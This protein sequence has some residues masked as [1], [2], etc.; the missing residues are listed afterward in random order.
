[1]EQLSYFFWNTAWPFL[2]ETAVLWVPAVALIFTWDW[3]IE[4]VNKAYLAKLKWILLEIKIPREVHKTP[5]AM[6]L[7]LNALYQSGGVGNPYAKFWDGK[8]LAWHSLEI[9]SIEGS[10]YF[11]IRTEARFKNLIE[12]QIYAQ[13]PQAEVQEVDDYTKF[14]PSYAPDNGWEYRGLELK[15]V[16]EDWIPIKTYVDYGLDS[17]GLMLEQE[18][19]IDPITPFIEF[20]GSLGKG[21]QF[22]YQ[23]IIRAG[24]GRFG[25]DAK[26]KDKDWQKEG[27][28]ALDKLMDGY[29]STE[30]TEEKK[31]EKGEKEK[32]VLKKV[33]GYKNLPPHLKEQVDAAERNLSKYGFD[34]GI[35]AM[36]I[37]QKDKFN[38]MRNPPEF[39]SVIK[40]FNS[41]NLNGFAPQN[42]TEGFDYWWE[43]WN[44]VRHIAR[45][46]KLFKK[47]VNRAWFYWPDGQKPAGT[48]T[49]EEVATIFH[50]PGSVS[51]TPTFERIEARK[52]EP[53]ANLPI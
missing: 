46:K 36:Y 19:R 31:N 2:R 27:R 12:N 20:M 1:M 45:R 33:G 34:F 21:E 53:P 30:I 3:W 50:F 38:G 25:V 14:V 32:K 26:G 7:V 15:L 40:Q 52:A 16:K 23:I 43:D 4:Y 22:W 47:F 24:A 49:T 11:F 44:N 6:E 29:A 41:P 10:V 13:Y 5:Q 42:I 48:L 37:A 18:Q 39:L 35:R 28:A 8:L 51:T 17:K 9:V